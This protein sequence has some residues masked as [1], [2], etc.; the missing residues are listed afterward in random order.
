MEPSK[1]QTILTFGE[2]AQLT[3][4]SINHSGP[5]QKKRKTMTK[6]RKTKTTTRKKK[7]KKKRK[8]STMKRKKKRRSA[9]GLQRGHQADLLLTTESSMRTTLSESVSLSRRSAI[10]CAC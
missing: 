1:S 5:S 7:V 6:R 9:N 8:K 3:P 4:P 2:L 10:S